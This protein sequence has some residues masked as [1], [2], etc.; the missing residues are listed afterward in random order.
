MDI[1]SPEVLFK[2]DKERLYQENLTCSFNIL[3]NHD[4]S[5]W[6]VQGSN[7]ED[8]AVKPYQQLDALWAFANEFTRRLVKNKEFGI[9][10][11]EKLPEISL[12]FLENEKGTQF[13]VVLLSDKVIKPSYCAI[14]LG[15]FC[16]Q[17]SEI[18]NHKLEG[19]KYEN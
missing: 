13:S 7:K 12:S 11:N 17:F 16:R 14:F 6:S 15:E 18:I 8:M 5:V 1:L 4:D 9:G 19:M 2:R 3:K 10:E